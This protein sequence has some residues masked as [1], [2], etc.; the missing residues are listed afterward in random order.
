MQCD[1]R[2]IFTTADTQRSD[3][4]FCLPT[5]NNIVID[6]LM[7]HHNSIHML[8]VTFRYRQLLFSIVHVQKKPPNVCDFIITVL[9]RLVT[10][11]V[12]KCSVAKQYIAK[13]KTFHN[14]G[15]DFFVLVHSLIYVRCP[16][17]HIYVYI[18]INSLFEA[19]M[20]SVRSSVF[21]LCIFRVA[22]CGGTD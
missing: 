10:R 22:H 14:K 20:F 18:Y 7:W 4:M 13:K 9:S 16:F 6:L 17:K 5:L 3:Q 19:D 21:A 15:C 11:K 12:R 8:M 2:E 1:V